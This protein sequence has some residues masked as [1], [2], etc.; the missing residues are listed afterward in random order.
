MYKK[1]ELPKTS[2]KVNDSYIGETI[3]QKCR[4]ITNN[5]QPITDGS[6]LIYEERKAGV[7]AAHDIRTDR[8]DASLDAFDA[9]AKSYRARREDKHKP[10]EDPKGTE[11][12]PVTEVKPT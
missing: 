3:E 8:W 11:P 5:G 6:P 2:L 4:R 9:A 1:Q 10:K 12:G 7:N